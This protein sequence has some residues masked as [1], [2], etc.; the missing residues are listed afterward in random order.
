MTVSA[1]E[2]RTRRRTCFAARV[3]RPGSDDDVRQVFN[4]AA[5]YEL[6][7][8]A[9]K[10]HLSR[11]GAAR[12]IF[13]GWRWSGIMTAR[14][15]LPVNVIVDRANASLPDQ[16][17]VSGAERPNV[18]PGVS[19]IPSGGPTP[20]DWID[21]RA[22]SIPAA[23]T[24]G[25]AGRNLARAPSLWQVNATLAKNI[26]LTE[27]VALQCRVEAFNVFNRAQFGSPQADLSTP[28]SFGV[29][30]TP[31]IQ[32]ATGSGTPRQ[33]QFALRVSF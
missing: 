10:A 3:K 24:F 15:G 6:P 29:I 2:N 27:R 16:F 9:G 25:N 22:F 12:A 28:L 26:S 17:S 18:V 32:S 14:T 8:G 31:V 11:P 20:N 7:L 19:L 33:F 4:L 23:G 30:T 13:G 21:P 5:V 1:A